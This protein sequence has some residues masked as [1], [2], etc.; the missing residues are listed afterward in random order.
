MRLITKT[1]PKQYSQRVDDLYWSMAKESLPSQLQE[2]SIVETELIR[3]L[4]L[5]SPKRYTDTLFSGIPHYRFAHLFAASEIPQR[6]GTILWLLDP[7][8]SYRHIRGKPFHITVVLSSLTTAADIE[9][10]MSGV[11]VLDLTEQIFCG[12]E[13]DNRCIVNLRSQKCYVWFQNQRTAI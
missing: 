9:L 12:V 11:Q 13:N 3:L 10:W 8:H 6:C 5:L 4:G 7:R 2:Y 1:T